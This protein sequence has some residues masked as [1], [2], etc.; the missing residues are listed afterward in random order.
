[1]F[2]HTSEGRFTQIFECQQCLSKKSK[3][4]KFGSKIRT[5]LLRGVVIVR[6]IHLDDH[7][8][9]RGW[10]LLIE[11]EHETLYTESSK[12]WSQLTNDHAD[13]QFAGVQPNTFAF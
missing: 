2:L 13:T 3:I 1:M 5:F 6:F 9:V 7:T 10:F 4:F 12:Q 8:Q 11:Y